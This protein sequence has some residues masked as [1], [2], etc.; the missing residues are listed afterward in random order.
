MSFQQS[1]DFTLILFHCTRRGCPEVTTKRLPGRWTLSDVSA[2]PPQAVRV[3]KDAV[4]ASGPAPSV[5][6]PAQAKP[7]TRVPPS[8]P[9]GVTLGPGGAR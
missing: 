7:A 8:S 2:P 4:G 3:T 1:G 6:P 9:S 5:P